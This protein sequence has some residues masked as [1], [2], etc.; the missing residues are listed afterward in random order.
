MGGKQEEGA[1]PGLPLP[2]LDL[3]RGL[4][5]YLAAKTGVEMTR[6]EKMQSALEEIVRVGTE[7]RMRY[8]SDPLLHAVVNLA[9]RGLGQG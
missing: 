3:D 7:D 4:V 6:E 1:G 5:E 9:K 2:Q 8:W